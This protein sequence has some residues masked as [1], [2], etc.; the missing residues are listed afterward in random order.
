M[1]MVLLEL[2]EREAEVYSRLCDL[3]VAALKKLF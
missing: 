2:A 3:F 1:I